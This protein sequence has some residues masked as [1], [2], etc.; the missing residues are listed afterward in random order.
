MR[1]SQ[2]AAEIC[3]TSQSLGS[4][5]APFAAVSAGV[6]RHPPCGG[7]RGASRRQGDPM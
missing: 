6:P 7:R 3:K 5:P 1:I 4:P 2:S